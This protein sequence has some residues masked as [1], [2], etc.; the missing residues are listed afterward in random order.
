MSVGD[1]EGVGPSTACLRHGKGGAL[2]VLRLD[3]SLMTRPKVPLRSA[4]NMSVHRAAWGSRAAAGLENAAA[5]A[6]KFGTPFDRSRAGSRVRVALCGST[7]TRQ[8]PFGE[9]GLPCNPMVRPA[10]G[11]HMGDQQPK[12]ACRGGPSSS[13]FI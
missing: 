5:T 7:H 6:R 3:P 2:S 10:L 4:N 1:R 9:G 13:S 12:Q 8:T 11:Q